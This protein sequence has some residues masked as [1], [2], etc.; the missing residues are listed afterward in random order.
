V[1]VELRARHDPSAAVVWLIALMAAFVIGGWVNLA[2]AASAAIA[3]SDQ[4]RWVR[5]VALG[6]PGFLGVV[7]LV[8]SVVEGD[9]RAAADFAVD[10]DLAGQ[11]GRLAGVMVLC[12]IARAVVVERRLVRDPGLPVGGPGAAR[13]LPAPSYRAGVLIGVAVAAAALVRWQVAA[14][15]LSDSQVALADSI[16]NGDVYGFDG[17]ESARL[18]PLAPVIAGLFPFGAE[19]VAALAAAAL[20]LVVV[21]WARLHTTWPAT[22]TAAGLAATGSTWWSGSLSALA[23]AA[24]ALSAFAL[25]TTDPGHRV[26]RVRSIPARAGVLLAL[27]ALSDQRLTLLVVLGATLVWADRGSRAAVSLV[28]A[29][30]LFLAPWLLWVERVSNSI[31]MTAGPVPAGGVRSLDLAGGWPARVV[32]WTILAAGLG[33]VVVLTRW[34]RDRRGVA[35]VAAPL[36]YGVVLIALS[37]SDQLGY[38]LAIPATAVMVGWTVGTASTRRRST[39]TQFQVANSR[40]PGTR[41]IQRW[42]G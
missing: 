38:G 34:R 41:T 2:V 31:G 12:V 14:P 8:G 37:P 6:L 19:P 29:A 4:R 40:R 11:A 5:S 42:L 27:A 9:R 25:L 22:V 13:P 21:I 1:T 20:L 24:L 7:M 39:S 30:G 36:G 33:A 3:L 10:R 23:G 15:V 18:V 35:F 17:V 32:D 28:G 16:V 26:A